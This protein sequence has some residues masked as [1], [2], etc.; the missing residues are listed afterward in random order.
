M[1]FL[2]FIKK[3]DTNAS[4]EVINAILDNNTQPL[5]N[6]ASTSALETAANMVGRAFTSAIVSGFDIEPLTLMDIGRNLI[7]RGEWSGI[8]DGNELIPCY[9]QNVKGGVS[10]RDWKYTVH[11]RSPNDVDNV[12]DLTYMEVIHVRSAFS[13]IEAWK[14]RSATDIAKLSS[15]LLSETINALR[16][17]MSTPTGYLLG[18]PA[19]DGSG[20]DL[21]E[22]RTTLKNLKG[23]IATIESK[24][25]LAQA[26]GIGAR[27]QEWNTQ[28]LG[29]NPPQSII[30]LM[31]MI[32]KETLQ[33][34]GI[35]LGLT[36]VSSTA[37]TRE[38]WRQ[39]LFGTIAPLAKLVEYELSMKLNTTIKLTFDELRASD[40]TGRARAFNSLVQGGMSLQEAANISGIL[41]MENTNE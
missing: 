33:L 7:R 23:R 26:S 19:R 13:Y 30:A 3:R 41:S 22:L 20:N 31:E 16:Y 2:N 10:K 11:V 29:A 1:K 38:A 35:P 8:Y 39:F 9:I 14:G 6:I 32:T 36:T 12:Y 40:I 24:Q 27:N 15:E 21:E 5:V 34:C 18:V 4:D 25:S 17:E 28:R 37:G